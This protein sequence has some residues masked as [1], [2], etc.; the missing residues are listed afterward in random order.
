MDGVT[1][2]A[3]GQGHAG[4]ED[5]LKDGENVNVNI[6][7]RESNQVAT[8]EGGEALTLMLPPKKPAMQNVE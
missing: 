7:R 6:S 1:S 5:I 3:E 2:R 8:L 4:A